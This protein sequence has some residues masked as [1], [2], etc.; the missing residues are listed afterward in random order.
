VHDTRFPKYFQ[1]SS[2]VVKYNDKTN[3]S[4]WP[5]DYHIACKVG[6]ADDDMFIIQLLPIY[7]ANSTRAWLDHLP[8]NMIDSWEDLKDIF[9]RNI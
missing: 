3:P 6:G 4:I 5:K 7:L 8:K 9:T 1:A 2:N